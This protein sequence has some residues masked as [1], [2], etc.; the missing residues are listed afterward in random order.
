MLNRIH[1]LCHLYF[2][3]IRRLI[4]QSWY[5]YV[6]RLDKEADMLFMNYGYTELTPEVRPLNLKK[7]DEKNRYFIQLYH[8]VAG[9]IDLEGLQVL[10][11]GS[12]R[13]GGAAYVMSYLKPRSLTGVDLTRG[14]IDFC[15]RHYTLPGLTFV[16]GEAGNLKF[17]DASFDAIINVE[18]S[19]CYPSMPKFL[20]EVYRLLK[21]GG[22]FLFADFRERESLETLRRQLRQSGLLF[23]RETNI[24]QNVLR[25]L[26]L[27]NDRKLGIIRRKVPR[28]V[29]A[30]FLEFAGMKGTDMFYGAM[31]SGAKSYWSFVLQKPV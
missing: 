25:A 14:A 8:H 31:E 17:E 1:L 23:R 5:A 24:S 20:G 22:H 2:P 30:P 27:D 7:A 28:L 9:A 6:S 10:E 19:H 11:V 26:E 3:N 15:R 12:G 18:S 4:N 21:P 29:H 13:G 16:Q